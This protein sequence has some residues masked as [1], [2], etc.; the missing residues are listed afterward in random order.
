MVSVFSE[1]LLGEQITHA[2]GEALSEEETARCLALVEIVEPLV[3]K[4]FWQTVSA[5]PGI[6]I[7]LV[8][9]V[10]LLDNDENLVATLSSGSCFGEA[11]LFSDDFQPYVA[12]ASTNL[13]LCYLKQ[14]VLQ[15][16]IER[17]PSIRDRLL[18]RAELWDL[19]MLCQQNWQEIGNI[20]DVPGMLKAL[21]LFERHDLGQHQQATLPKDCK[22]LLLRKGELQHSEGL[23]LTPG[24]IYP[25]SQQDSWQ[26]AQPTIAYIIRDANWLPAVEHWQQLAEFIDPEERPVDANDRKQRPTKSKSERSASVGNIIPFPQRN[27]E[28]QQKQKR[29]K[30]YFP[31]PKVRVEHWWGRVTQQ[32]PFFQQHSASDCGAACLVMIS[33][34]W[35]KRFSVNRL[36]ELADTSRDGVS[37]RNLAAAAENLGFASRPVKASFDKL[38]QQ[39]LPAIAHWEG[40]HFV[41]IYEITRKRVII[42]DP[43]I[44]MRTLTAAEFI[45]DWSGYALLL[46]PTALLKDSKEEIKGFWKFYELL[47][48]H[49]WVLVEIFVASVLIQLSGLVSP[50]F[51][52][53][54]LDRVIVQGSVATL[55]A[56]ALGMLV[57]GFFNIV[58]SAVRQY[59]MD[60]TA[61]RISVA[62]LIGFIKHTLHLPLSFFES[63]CVGDITSRIQETQKIQ[64]FLTGETLSVL[65]DL[66]T[67]SI[68]LVIMFVYSWQ[69]ALVAL[70][71]VPPFFILVFSSTGILRRISNEMFYAG[72]EESSYLIQSLTGIRSIRSM[73]VEQTVRWKWEELLNNVV[74]KGF[75]AQIIGNRLGIISSSINLLSSTALMWYGASMVIHQQLTIGQLVAFNM[76]LGNVL[77]PFQRLALL[78]NG[79]QEIMIS[80]ERINDILEAKPEED[81]ENHPRQSIGQFRGHIRFEKV[82]FRYNSQ[83]ETNVLQNLSFEIQPQQTVAVVGRSGSGKT[84]LSKLILG[85]YSPTEGKILIDGQDLNYISLRSLRSQVGVVDQDTFLFSGTVRENISIA[86]PEATLEEIMEAARMAG[87]DE[88]IQQLPMGYESQIGEGG[89]LLS[90]GQRQRVAIAR[91]L[92]GNPR[93]L[94]FDE[95]TSHLDT[96]SERIIQNNLRTI[97]EG[98]SSVIIAHRLSTIRNADLIL[99]LDRGVLVE[100]GTHEELIAKKGHYYYLNQ[101]QFAQVG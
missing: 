60:H 87:A 50:I 17:H 38:A 26:I 55:N 33:R 72:A 42:A 30:P 82:T 3:A 14:E 70:L 28:P 53:M 25:A 5:N 8:G 78:W 98:R 74:K 71:T 34:Y 39:P 47:R 75:F 35:G 32:Y 90:G 56:I 77:G 97:L 100:S 6:Y 83:N 67:L 89:G 93:L 62:M 52:Q 1:H 81:L 88:F 65:L 76:L 59:L 21:S 16:L 95:A 58:V 11:T 84:T 96:E 4:Q 86:H 27:S 92:L 69:M 68:Y 19:V 80:T 48:P 85:L 94:I 46:Q 57:F 10:R 31:S 54:L 24:K 49:F 41:V 37:L 91:A 7:V 63:R 99:V 36:R 79:L 61:N 45:A 20:S 101:Q 22:F 64:S 2:L 73:G 51:T 66:L 12:R 43:A 29:H 40:K 9:K 18:K 23:L 15:A 44:G 13:K